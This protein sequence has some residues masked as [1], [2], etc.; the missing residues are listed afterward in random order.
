[1]INAER[2]LRVLDGR[3]DHEVSLVLY[4]RAALALG[5]DDPPE[6]V[7]RSMDVDA[8][9]PVSQIP[10]LRDDAAFWEAQDATNRELEH[11]GLYVT[12]LFAAD[13]IILRRDWEQHIA[14][15]SRP[16][17]RW[18]RLARP[19]TLD[20]ILT[21]MMRGDD[22]QDM[23]DIAFLLGHDRITPNELERAF[24]EAVI[25]DLE[26]LRE[27]FDR[28]RPRVLDLARSSRA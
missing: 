10:S 4:G 24:A 7:T 20:L 11:D 18:L 12:H 25:P 15:I 6:A 3:L 9:I 1:M 22:P 26:E 21:K 23:A 27:A 2:I 28:A 13:Q 8:I 16:P 5:F 17:T 19:A 14:P